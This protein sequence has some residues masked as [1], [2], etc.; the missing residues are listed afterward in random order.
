MSNE[1]HLLNMYHFSR[2]LRNILNYTDCCG[3]P[4]TT[5]CSLLDALLHNIFHVL[6]WFSFYVHKKKKTVL[7]KT[8]SAEEPA[9][10]FQPTSPAYLGLSE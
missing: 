3:I 4:T 9:V 5:Q 1:F 10:V 8:L 7:K 6:P 2:S